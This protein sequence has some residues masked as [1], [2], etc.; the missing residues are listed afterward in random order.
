MGDAEQL[1]V[2]CQVNSTRCEIISAPPQG[3]FNTP[4]ILHIES[5]DTPSSP[6]RIPLE[7]QDSEMDEDGDALGVEIREFVVG[8]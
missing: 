6:P 2:Q 3:C 7:E 8:L 1:D 4:C 5:Q